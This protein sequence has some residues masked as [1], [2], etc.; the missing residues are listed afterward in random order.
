[1]TGF[2]ERHKIVVELSSIFYLFVQM[3]WSWHF[4]GWD[5]LEVLWNCYSAI[6]VCLYIFSNGNYW[7]RI[8]YTLTEYLWSLWLQSSLFFLSTS[9]FNI[10]RSLSVNFRFLPQLCLIEVV[11]HCIRYVVM[12]FNTVAQKTYT[13]LTV[14]VTD[15]PT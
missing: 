10:W 9:Y 1:M 13:M 6:N 2:T 8:I 4:F 12:N 11:L 7:N 15:A 14:V 3:L 5:M